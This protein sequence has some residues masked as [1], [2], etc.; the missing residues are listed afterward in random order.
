MIYV[1]VMNIRLRFKAKDYGVF[2][3]H[4]KLTIAGQRRYFLYPENTQAPPQKIKAGAIA[5]YRYNNRFLSQAFITAPRP[6][7]HNRVTS[8]AKRIQ[9]VSAGILATS[10]VTVLPALSRG[11]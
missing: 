10:R 11:K 9:P 8:I 3:G 4:E 1:H 5:V 7:T 2:S 6:A